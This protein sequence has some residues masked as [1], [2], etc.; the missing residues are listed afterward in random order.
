MRSMGILASRVGTGG[1]SLWLMM[2]T[3][4]A[5]PPAGLKMAS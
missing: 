1:D 2:E 4:G 5:E 3:P